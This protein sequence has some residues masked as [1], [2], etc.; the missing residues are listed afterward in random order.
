[1]LEGYWLV[2][3]LLPLAAVSGWYLRGRTWRPEEQP[4][5][6]N[7]DYLKGISHLV[8]EDADK[9]I[10]TFVRLLEVDNETVET[11][12]ALGSLFRRQGEVDRALRVHQNLVAR[13]N[14]DPEH[15]NQARLELAQDYQ[16]AGVLDRAENLY[17]EL[18]EQGMFMGRVLRGLIT[19]YEAQ[20]DWEQALQT[21]RHLESVHGHTLR[22]I[23]AQYYCE[24]ADDALAENDQVNALKYVKAARSEFRDC[25]RASIL[26][27]QIEEKAEKY[28]SAIKAYE[29]VTKQDPDLATEVLDSL[30]RCYS[31]QNNLAGYRVYL[32][33]LAER[34]DG[35]GP[36]IALAR[37]LQRQD[38]IDSAVT[39]LSNYLERNPNWIGFYHLLDLTW[40]DSRA[41]LTGP[42]NSLRESLRNIL[43]QQALYRCGQCGFTGRYLH[44]QCPSCQHWNTM[45]PL[46]DIKP[47]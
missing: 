15:R 10:E 12:L 13:P 27:G 14:L 23:T 36:Q 22:A 7:Q 41:G 24:M 37:L 45:V 6:V 19:I 42:L 39:G 11:H 3:I 31:N 33:Q 25:T 17:N 9:A 35:V 21:T 18:L 47:L 5:V 20:R 44:W 43:A 40:S 28:G 1:M 38:D 26:R 16:R 34:Y 30:E 32:D 2:L 29:R 4:P 8:N 46:D